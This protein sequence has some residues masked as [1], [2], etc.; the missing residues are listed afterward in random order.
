M[1][2]VFINET[3]LILTEKIPNNVKNNVIFFE[4]F[5]ILNFIKK[6]DIKSENFYILT[7][8]LE[9]DWLQ[10]KANFK[11]IEAAGGLVKNKNEDVL[12][13]F[14][15]GKWDLP[16][17]K[18][19]KNESRET[20]AIR[21]VEEECGIK[22]LEIIN[23]LQ[24]TFHIFVRN[25]KYILKITHWFLMYSDYTNELTPQIEEDITE[26]S[27]KN[28]K[29]VQLALQNTYENIKLLFDTNFV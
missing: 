19:E 6:I 11:V 3:L 24:D 21:E 17:G 18:I 28:K 23:L 15:L 13:I 27:W 16:K 20:A 29:E 14:R 9:D 1:Y 2:K 26:V 7:K 22:E 10:F 8:N 5:N 4:D 25:N 12:F